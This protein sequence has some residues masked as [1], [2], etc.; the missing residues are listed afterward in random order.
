[1]GSLKYESIRAD[2]EKKV[3]DFVGTRHAVLCSSGRSAIRFSLLALGNSSGDEVVVPDLTCELLAHAVYGCGAKPRFCDVDQNTLALS[4][5]D[6]QKSINGDTKTII[7]VHPFGFPVDPKPFQE[8]AE[9]KGIVIVEDACQAL[10]STIDGKQAGS[11][12]DV[13]IFSF[14]KFLDVESGGAVVTDNDEI[15]ERIRHVREENESKSHFASIGYRLLTFLGLKSYKPLHSVF[16]SDNYLNELLSLRF[17]RKH[18]RII[19]H[20][21]EISPHL[22]EL[23]E[24]KSLTDELMILP[25]PYHNYVRRRLEVLEIAILNFEFDTLQRRVQEAK[26]AAEFYRKNLEENRIRKLKVH[27]NYSPSYL[28]YP[29]IFN[30]D[31]A[32]DRCIARLVGAGFK[33]NYLYRPL[34]CSP[35]FTQNDGTN[36]MDASTYLSKHLLP[37]PLTPTVGREG[38]EEITRIVNSKD[39]QFA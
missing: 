13:G 11:F 15:A 28:R 37:L 7:L 16:L 24:S 5:S 23:A 27:E 8:I 31:A 9:D 39:M 18:F 29:I 14:N 33:I 19:N 4:H 17:A 25:G 30:D 22:D 21:I 32:R 1:M 10:G 26:Q 2:F 12:G 6:L 34:H 38:A 35:F 20:W 3:A 36:T